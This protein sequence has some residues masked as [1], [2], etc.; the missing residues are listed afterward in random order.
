M[1]I[2][3]KRS[4]VLLPT[5][6]PTRIYETIYG[7]LGLYDE[8]KTYAMPDKGRFMY[9]V[10]Q[11]KLQ[12]GDWYIW[13]NNNQVCKVEGELHILN[14]HIMNKQISKIIASTDKSLGLP[15]IPNHFIKQYVDLYN[16]QY[17]IEEVIVEYKNTCCG[18]CDGITDEC[19]GPNEVVLR[20]NDKDNTI[21][22]HTLR[23]NFSL[24][25]VNDLLDKVLRAYR[26]D[27]LPRGEY[28]DYT[29]FETL[30]EF[31]KKYF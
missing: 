1:S 13:H 8:E 26:D 29:I 5:E 12:I 22:L 20:L 6:E 28:P 17:V 31:K 9:I 18:R 14:N 16:K 10:N 2:L 25:E 11:D 7:G 21:Y 30:K 27:H 3:M 24:E 15:S 19:T 23:D 4:V